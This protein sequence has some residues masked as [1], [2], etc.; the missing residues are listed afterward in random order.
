MINSEHIQQ[1]NGW[2]CFFAFM[3]ALCLLIWGL[4]FYPIFGNDPLRVAS[5]WI[6]GPILL[7]C[8]MV[9][10]LYVIASIV[11]LCHQCVKRLC[12]CMKQL[13]TCIKNKY[14]PKTREFVNV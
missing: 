7:L 9:L 6:F 5:G 1:R 8:F 10:A 2:L 11:Y 12:I 14:P 4:E 13:F 3:Y